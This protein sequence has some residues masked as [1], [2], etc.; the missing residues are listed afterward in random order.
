MLISVI[1]TVY[2]KVEYIEQ[3]LR[4]IL[5]QTYHD[6]E[7]IVVNDGSTDGS[8][9]VC[10]E[11][12]SQDS[13]IKVYTQCN[14]G[15]VKSRKIGASKAK[16]EFISFVDGDDWIDREMIERMVKE[17]KEN[18]ADI[19]LCN[20]YNCRK[21]KLQSRNFAL[22][23]GFYSLEGEETGIFDAYFKINTDCATMHNVCEKLIRKCV[24]TSAQELVDDQVT[25]AEDLVFSYAL[26]H[27]CNG[28]QVVNKPMYFYRWVEDSMI[29]SVN[30]S[31][32][33]DVEI[34]YENILH[35]RKILGNSWRLDKNVDVFFR[36]WMDNLSDAIW[37]N[38]SIR[39]IFPYEC[40]KMN[41]KVIL[42]GMGKVGN[43]FRQQIES[44]RY[45]KLVGVMD[46]NDT[47]DGQLTLAD[48]DTLLYDS[49]VISV[50]SPKAAEAIKQTLLDN[51]VHANKIVW[52]PPVLV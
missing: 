39:Y 19:V 36:R 38:Y 52:V 42:Y 31:V 50:L 1:V 47:L 9:T 16:G 14:Q 22:G 40:I 51:G 29:H 25:R 32:L 8:E 35:T 17:Q 49:I 10:N 3:C 12:A 41:S 18:D 30:V 23:D 34:A 48:L 24:F 44:G 27:L 11:L 21:D 45:C 33:R 5:E 15:L 43:S 2:N 20:Y 6:I 4:S 26:L 7:I 37:G 28:I 13:R 46:S